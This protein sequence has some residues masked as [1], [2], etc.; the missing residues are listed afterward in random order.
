MVPKAFAFMDVGQMH[1]IDRAVKGR[2]G[3]AD[4]NRGMGIGAG[5]DHD[6]LG[7]IAC[8]VDQIY[9]GAFVI[10]VLKH[11]STAV[12]RAVL[13][14]HALDIGQRCR[15]I[16]FGFPFSQ[17][18]EIG[19]IENEN[20]WSCHYETIARGKHAPFQRDVEG[21]PARRQACL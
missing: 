17:E 10:A 21:G 19:T 13:Q 14:T 2:Q 9:E 12:C 15:A 11:Q 20:R 5:V 18:I 16:D 1:L 8:P 4:R 6:A 7:H 3:I